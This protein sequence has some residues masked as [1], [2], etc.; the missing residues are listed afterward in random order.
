M[1]EDS[2]P[3]PVLDEI[4]VRVVGSL[5]EKQFVTPDNYPLTLNALTAACNQ[6]SNREP[7]MELD[8]EAV[9]KSLAYLGRLSLARAVHRSDSRALRYR[10]E[11]GEKL[12]LH[13]PEL[14]ALCVLMLRGPQT[15]GEIRTRTARM[16][17][18]TE[19][20]HVEITLEALA[21]LSPPLVVLLPR[22]RGQKEARWA[23]LLSGEPRIEAMEEVA[24][25]L[26][27]GG[28]GGPAPSGTTRSPGVGE[29]IHALEQDLA[30][31][32]DEVAA[33]R[34]QLDAFRRQFE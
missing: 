15:A 32:R 24:S 9:K 7:V 28:Q 20:R 33:L 29:R 30:A 2:A 1:T 8:E 17:E 3:A 13:A 31:L 12:H 27:G 4:A 34:G 21:G 14:A 11:L 19:P 10:Q 6:S 16:F 25:G 18:F 26:D 23:H 5:I 22:Q